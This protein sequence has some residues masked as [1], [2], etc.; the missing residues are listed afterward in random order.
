MDFTMN[1]YLRLQWTD[2]ALAFEPEDNSGRNELTLETRDITG[3]PNLQNIWFGFV[4]NSCSIVGDV[5]PSDL[6]E[7]EIGTSFIINSA[8]L[9]AMPHVIVSYLAATLPRFQLELVWRAFPH[10]VHTV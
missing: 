2:K 1:Y 9:V 10:A 6:A 3:E 8:R 7:S 5:C 4:K